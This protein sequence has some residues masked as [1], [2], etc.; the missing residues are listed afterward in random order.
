MS[1]YFALILVETSDT[2]SVWWLNTVGINKILGEGGGLISCF[3]LKKKFVT[4]QILRTFDKKN[5]P[6]FF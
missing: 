6:V 5:F 3:F 4:F 1:K 2:Y